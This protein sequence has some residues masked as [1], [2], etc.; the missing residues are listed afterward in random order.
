LYGCAGAAS[1]GATMLRIA[2][3]WYNIQY[4]NRGDDACAA[5]ARVARRSGARVRANVSVVEPLE[6]GITGR[7]FYNTQAGSLNVRSP[8]EPLTFHQ[9]LPGYAPTP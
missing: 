8:R 2:V 6:T 3:G 7:L 9:R 4:T 1:R 5:W